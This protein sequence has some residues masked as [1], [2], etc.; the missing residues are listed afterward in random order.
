[1]MRPYQMEHLRIKCP[2]CF[3][4]EILFIKFKKQ[5]Q[6]SKL[7]VK[8]ICIDVN[9][10]HALFSHFVS[11]NLKPWF[12]S[13]SSFCPEAC[14]P[15]HFT[16]IRLLIGILFICPNWQSW[17]YPPQETCST[18]WARLAW[19]SCWGGEEETHRWDRHRWTMR[20]AQLFHG[21]RPRGG[22]WFEPSFNTFSAEKN[23][24]HLIAAW[25]TY[26]RNH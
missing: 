19:T 20:P 12:C 8:D 4:V 16:V 25:G 15:F 2:Y 22:G 26:R 1:M 5:V 7:T 6:T 14:K 11:Q 24:F 3:C 18:P 23:I 17:Q 10:L 21:S 9:T 13:A